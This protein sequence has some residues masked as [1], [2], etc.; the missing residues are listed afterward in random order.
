[1]VGKSFINPN[2]KKSDEMP[3][4]VTAEN[5]Y[6]HQT[7]LIDGEEVQFRNGIGFLS[8]NQLLKQG[9][10]TLEI[11]DAP[12]LYDINDDKVPDTTFLLRTVGTANHMSSF[13]IAS[14]ISLRNGFNGVNALYLDQNIESSMFVYKNGEISVGYT[15]SDATSTVKQKYFILSDSI[16]KQVLHK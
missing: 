12:F 11:I 2:Q 6:K 14:L 13:Y 10:T 8:P 7:Y 16:L 5:T 9:T 1:M 4:A 15:T 3:P